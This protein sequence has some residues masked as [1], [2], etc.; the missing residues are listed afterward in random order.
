MTVVHIIVALSSIFLSLFTA[1]SPSKNRIKLHY[2][3][4]AT[5]LITGGFLLFLNPAHLGKSCVLGLL[6]LV[7]ATGMS[8]IAN[9]KFAVA[10]LLE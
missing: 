9:K 4:T 8:I 3:M 10:G 5:T 6:Y 7:Y 2:V 1:F